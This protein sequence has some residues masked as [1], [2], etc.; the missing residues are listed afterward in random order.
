M[1]LS[2][3]VYISQVKAGFRKDDLPQFND[4]YTRSYAREKITGIQL[5]ADPFVL[6]IMEG[7]F[8]ALE[9]NLDRIASNGFIQDPE[10]ILIA[11]V[12]DRLFPNWTLE[13]LSSSS[14][15]TQ[16]L[17]TLK[18]L[19]MQAQSAVDSVPRVIPQLIKQFKEQFT[20][21]DPQSSAA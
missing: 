2:C 6:E 1:N 4:L 17:E 19:G 20:L 12:Q 16:D 10:I 3:F 5:V 11:S 18:V 13:A 9:N 21:I 14:K 8:A 15:Q 7:D